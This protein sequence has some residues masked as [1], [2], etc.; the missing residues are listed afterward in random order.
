MTPVYHLASVPVSTMARV[1]GKARSSEKTAIF[2]TFPI[3]IEHLSIQDIL[4]LYQE[5]CRPWSFK[6]LMNGTEWAHKSIYLF[7]KHP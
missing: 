7:K 5:G 2:G 1:T 3:Q 6:R 4:Y